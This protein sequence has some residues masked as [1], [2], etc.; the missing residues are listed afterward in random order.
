MK[1]AIKFCGGCNPEYDRVDLY[2][3]IVSSAGDAIEWVRVE[4]SGYE[5]VLLICGCLTAC[6]E[7]ELHHVSR[8]VSVRH[9]ELSP[10]HVVTQLLGRGK[11]DADQDER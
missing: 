4:D 6:P 3:R 8:L 1:V 10:D 9:D 7:D 2:R 5:A 11:S